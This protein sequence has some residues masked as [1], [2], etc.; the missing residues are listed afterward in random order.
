MLYAMVPNSWDRMIVMEEGGLI[1]IA[2]FDT[3]NKTMGSTH[4]LLSKYCKS[5]H[6]REI[7]KEQ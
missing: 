7:F 5:S 1:S 6:Y 3:L 2:A 4:E